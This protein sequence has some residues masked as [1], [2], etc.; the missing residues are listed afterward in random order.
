MLLIV[1]E[2]KQHNLT[3][4]AR[5]YYRMMERKKIENKTKNIKMLKSDRRSSDPNIPCFFIYLFNFNTILFVVVI[6][7]VVVVLLFPLSKILVVTYLYS[8]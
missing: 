5:K 4:K 6:V 7:F 2:T 8:L 1:D 3:S